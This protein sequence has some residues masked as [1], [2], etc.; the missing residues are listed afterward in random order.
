MGRGIT[1]RDTEARVI[2]QLRGQYGGVAEEGGDVVL[3]TEA[4]CEGGRADSA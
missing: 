4:C 3:L 2:V 1:L